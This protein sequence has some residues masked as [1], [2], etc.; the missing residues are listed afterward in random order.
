MSHY[1]IPTPE[2]STTHFHFISSIIIQICTTRTFFLLLLE[3]EL[4]GRSV[5]RLVGLSFLKGR[6][7]P[8]PCSFRSTYFL[9]IQ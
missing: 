2:K 8:L 7:V 5:G 6:K 1:V 4:V 3:V 9:V